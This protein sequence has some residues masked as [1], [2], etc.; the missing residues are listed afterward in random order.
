[1]KLNSKNHTSSKIYSIYNYL[2]I[3]LYQILYLILSYYYTF[4][5]IIFI[6]NKIIYLF[7]NVHTYF[8]SIKNNSKR[9]RKSYTNQIPN[10]WYK[11]CDS[12]DIKRGE[13]KLINA[14]HREYLLYRSDTVS[15][16]INIIDPYCP[17]MG[18]NLYNGGKVKGNCVQ[19]P[20][21]SWC[22]NG[23]GQVED[24]PNCDKIHKVQAEK[25]HILEKYHM[26]LFWYHTEN[27]KPEYQ[28]FPKIDENFIYRGNFKSR[29]I[30]MNIQEFAENAAD[31]QHFSPVH[32]NFMIPWTGIE[33]TSIKV[34]HNINWRIDKDLPHKS[35]FTN[36]V[37]GIS[38]FNKNIKYTNAKAEIYFTGPPG[39][40]VFQFTLPLFSL[41]PSIILFQSHL[42]VDSL[43]LQCDFNYYSHNKLP[44]F[45]VSYVIGS[46]ISQWHNDLE[47]WENKIY[48][49]KPYL[50][51]TDG[52]ILKNRRW[53]KQFYSLSDW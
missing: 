6:S 38:I 13:L 45:I 51:K 17:H 37:S 35:Y 39:V 10:G 1:M 23:E 31:Y 52:P 30:H 14:F 26:I 43:E 40:V 4:F 33:L 29:N 28:P 50:V 7:Y 2:Y 8:N 53:M 24:I 49:S 27:K 19:C 3:I 9:R 42:P 15:E 48:K 46:W 47:I 18:A 41:L 36:E 5:L 20:F 22:I 34:C 44:N 32:G 12:W 25:Y 21:H 16:N 11:L